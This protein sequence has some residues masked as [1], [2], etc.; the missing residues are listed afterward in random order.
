MNIPYQGTVLV[1]STIPKQ[2]REDRFK[3]K[4]AVLH[5]VY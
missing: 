1:A 2:S 5:V 4:Y 3:V